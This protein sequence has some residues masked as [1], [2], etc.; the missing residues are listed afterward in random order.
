MGLLD[1]IKPKSALEKAARDVRE[2]YAQPDVRRA[3]MD[4]LLEL[5]TEE[6]FN[7]LLQRFSIVA[8]GQ[9]ADEAE[10][11]DLVQHLVDAGEAA[12]PA[13]KRYI[14]QEKTIAF[15]IRALSGI[16]NDA[17]M[18]EFLFQTLEAYEPL[19]HRSTQAKT[20]L[21][22]ALSDRAKAAQA[23][24]L[25]PYLGDHHDDV[26]FAVVEALQHFANFETA[27]PLIQLCCGDAVSG[28]VQRR[29]ALALVELGW[30]VKEHYD[31]F[32]PELK[33]DLL[34]GKKGQL[35]KKG[36]VEPDEPEAPKKKK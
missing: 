32:N 34:V 33:N 19:D 31:R 11:R 6:A 18:V 16:L 28:R 9:I 36:H 30:P 2:V 24:R 1:F 12:V 35:V 21:I 7:A 4:K 22:A 23:P 15:P 17:D 3:A 25:V 13:L 8:N 14:R 20:T 27:L 29:A 5:G 10:K 26:Q